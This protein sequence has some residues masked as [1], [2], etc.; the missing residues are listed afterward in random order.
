MSEKVLPEFI[1][2]GKDFKIYIKDLNEYQKQIY[3][4]MSIYV[5]G[6]VSAQVDVTNVTPEQQEYL[7]IAGVVRLLK[8]RIIE[9]GE[10]EKVPNNLY[11]N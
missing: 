11:R 2:L 4:L 6:L 10:L 5:K 3:W 9:I 8:N 7:K 1:E